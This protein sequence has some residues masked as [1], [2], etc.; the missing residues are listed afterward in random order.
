M[1]GAMQ[2]AAQPG[3]QARVGLGVACMAPIVMGSLQ[4][5]A[6]LVR[7]LEIRVGLSMTLCTRLMPRP[8]P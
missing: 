5:S 7:Q 2:Q 4:A 8:T 6:T 1:D 3:R